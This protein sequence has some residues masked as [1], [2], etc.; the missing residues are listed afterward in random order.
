ME[1][2]CRL[3]HEVRKSQYSI[4]VDW[5]VSYLANFQ[6]LNEVYEVQVIDRGLLSDTVW[7]PPVNLNM[8]LDVD[9]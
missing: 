9:A 5:V 2:T 8:R 3:S 7:E 6:K 4:N 1:R